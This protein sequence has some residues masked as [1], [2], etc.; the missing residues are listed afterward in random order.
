MEPTHEDIDELIDDSFPTEVEDIVQ[1]VSDDSTRSDHDDM[2]NDDH[3]DRHAKRRI[4][5]GIDRSEIV[6]KA[7]SEREE[8]IEQETVEVG[9]EDIEE[10]S[11]DKPECF[12][13]REIVA[14]NRFKKCFEMLDDEIPCG[15]DKS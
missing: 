10:N 1:D 3:D 12:V 2:R 6:V 5:V 13:D 8:P 11:A 15:T 14:Q 7:R 9:S 4:D